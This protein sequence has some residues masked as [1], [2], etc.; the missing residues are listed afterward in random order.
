LSSASGLL[1]LCGRELRGIDDSAIGAGSRSGLV[2]K[3]SRNFCNGTLISGG[4]DIEP[5]LHLIIVHSSSRK[6]N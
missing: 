3:A 2:L 6:E 5:E 4:K 1:F